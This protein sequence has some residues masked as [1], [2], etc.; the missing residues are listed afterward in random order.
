M[1]MVMGDGRVLAVI[2]VIRVG[3]DFVRG[4]VDHELE[5]ILGG[6][7]FGEVVFGVCATNVLLHGAVTFFL[8][9]GGQRGGEEVA[10]EEDSRRDIVFDSPNHPGQVSVL[11][12]E[13]E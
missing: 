10:S 11:L 13:R 5:R 1:V 7:Q 9:S 3:G 8:A 2:C 6:G 4:S 12:S